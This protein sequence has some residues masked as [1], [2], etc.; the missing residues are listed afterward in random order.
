MQA[1]SIL[2]ERSVLFFALFGYLCF[3]ALSQWIVSA[4]ADLDQAEQLL[5]S[6]HFA[7]GYSAQHPLYTWLAT[8]LFTVAPLNLLSLLMLKVFLLSLTLVAMLALSRRLGMTF[9]QQLM[10]IA[11][12]AMIPQFMWESQRDL[13]HSVL[14]T[15]SVSFLLLQTLRTRDNPT[16]FNY[17]LIGVIAALALMS[18]YNTSVFIGA[19]ALAVL[20]TPTYRPLLL[21]WKIF[22]TA[23]AAL[24]VL[25]P[26]AAWIYSHIDTATASAEKLHAGEN[27]FK[28]IGT[29]AL[30]GLAFAAPLIIVSLL[31]FKRSD[32]NKA[33][34]RYDQNARFLNNLLLS[35]T[36]LLSIF[37]LYTGAT[38]IKDR[39]FQPLLFFIPLMAAY[40]LDPAQK[41][42]RLFIGIATVLALAVMLILPLRTVLAGMTHIKSRPNIPYPSLMQ[43]L[44]E[45][46]HPVT[47]LAE[48][49]LIGG[50]TV[51]YFR[52]ASVYVPQY[53]SLPAD[54]N[55]SVLIL[56]DSPE[57]YNPKFASWAK[58]HHGID[59]SVLRF[60]A[61]SHPH[62]YDSQRIK[63]IYW[64]RWPE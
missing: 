50:N 25:F 27:P 36:V 17:A 60:Q 21:S 56:C 32:W 37:V 33:L 30:S 1:K 19:L 18:K 8:A 29:M 7:W 16:F 31:V 9:H 24:A 57:C 49:K 59:F 42:F 62:Y 15:T 51:P 41:R 34:N 12:F 35:V 48:S 23:A 38:G 46:V 26:H 10:M 55:G 4:T 28:S 44:S 40:Y 45:K 20:A 11:G 13:T 5:L 2:S 61:L 52:N 6:Q 43:S 63:T 54:K 64:A 22:I 14:A 3:N 47:V 53:A 39:W 58:K